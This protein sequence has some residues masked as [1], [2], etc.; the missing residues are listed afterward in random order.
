MIYVIWHGSCFIYIKCDT[1]KTIRI[2][3]TIAMFALLGFSSKA[4][5]PETVLANYRPEMNLVSTTSI[6]PETLAEMEYMKNV[7]ELKM[8]E[9]RL[10]HLMYRMERDLKYVAPS[11]EVIEAI[12]SLD[13]LSLIVEKEIRYV[14]PKN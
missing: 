7:Y 13:E 8:T 10:E 6:P 12:E 11:P 9:I 5:K 3:M 14:A 2:L 4:Q 1:M